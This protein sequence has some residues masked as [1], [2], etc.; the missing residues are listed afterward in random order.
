MSSFSAGPS[1][2]ASNPEIYSYQSHRASPARNAAPPSR[3]RSTGALRVATG[4]RATLVRSARTLRLA[5]RSHLSHLILLRAS[6][7]QSQSSSS[8]PR[9]RSVV[10]AFDTKLRI[11]CSWMTTS[12]TIWLA[13]DGDPA[14][15]FRADVFLRCE[16][17]RA[18]LHSLP[19]GTSR[20]QWNI[21]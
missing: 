18:A 10:V 5:S 19:R 20:S 4:S 14:C 13:Q 2:F 9:S 1:P 21:Q 12:Q 11:R 17:R 16:D 8:Q 6:T 3:A 15:F 7:P